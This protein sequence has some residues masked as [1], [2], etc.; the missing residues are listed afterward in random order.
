[1]RRVSTRSGLLSLLAALPAAAQI[2]PPQAPLS[3]SVSEAFRLGFTVSGA[4]AR[5]TGMGGAFVAVADD[6]TAASFNPAGL[7]QLRTF[8][9]S[10]V[11]RKSAFDLSLDVTGDS[12]TAFFIPQYDRYEGRSPSEPQFISFS[13][14]FQIGSRNAVV[15]LSRQRMFTMNQD[16][17]RSWYATSTSTAGVY[18]TLN[19]Q[20]SQKGDIER[21]TLASAIEVTPRLLMGV[22]WNSWGGS[23]TFH[24]QTDAIQLPPGT[25]RVTPQATATLDQDSHLHGQNFGVGLLWVSE[26]I[27]VGASYQG[28]FTA[29]YSY[30]GYYESGTTFTNVSVVTQGPLETR[31]RTYDVHWPETLSVGLS[32]R[33]HPQWQVALDWSRTPWTKAKFSAPGTVFDGQ[34]LLDPAAPATTGTGAQPADKAVDTEHLRTGVEYLW[35]VRKLIIPI[36]VGYFHEPQPMRDAISGEN[37]VLT[38]FTVGTGVKWGDLRA[39]IAYKRGTS[40]RNVGSLHTPLSV[41]DGVTFAAGDLGLSAEKLKSTETILSLIYQFKGEWLRKAARW[42]IVSPE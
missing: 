32:Y 41:G 12:K 25:R 37:R 34:N 16:Y 38:G 20:V 15:Q 10:L 23:W 36:R 4:G 39:D 13:A 24:S 6:A 30:S 26:Q 21:W 33:P 1:M 2:L 27:R 42:V 11:G 28:P 31:G 17:T 9:V 5:A 14:P 3:L 19:E 8:E 40:H 29:K 18:R 7:A 35:F 22:S